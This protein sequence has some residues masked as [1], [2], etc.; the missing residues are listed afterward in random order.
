MFYR[1][2]TKRKKHKTLR[3]FFA[4]VF[5]AFAVYL[6][7]RYGDYLAFWRY[8]DNKLLAE[9]DEAKSIEDAEQ[10]LSALTKAKDSV[11][12]YR[13]E[14][15]L[16]PN[17]YY[18]TADVYYSS[19]AALLPGTFSELLIN[20]RLDGIKPS[21]FNEFQRAVRYMRKGTAL[22]KKEKPDDKYAI[23]FAKSCFYTEFLDIKTVNEL[24]TDIDKPSDIENVRFCSMIKILAGDV[25][26]GFE[27]LEE[28]GNISSGAEGI[29]FLAALQAKTG[30][31][32]NAIINYKKLL[33]SQ[34][35]DSVLKLVR[36][37]LGRIYYKQSLYSEAMEEFSE[38]GKLDGT[39][40][41]VGLW[42]GKTYASMGASDKARA[43]WAEAL[44]KDKSNAELKRLLDSI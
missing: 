38:A 26:G 30:Q 23:I 14:N 25:D 4:A 37:S 44:T 11:K 1:Y 6:G 17:S 18:Y 9:I 16:N 40:A 31:Y 2:K 27:L 29:L 13:E 22:A 36:M 28:N 35:D 10:R 7:Y 3:F 24:L 34:T 20:D 33:N 15:P 41:D 39:D 32:T 43:V 5:L 21:A 8:S 12:N 42:T 19:G